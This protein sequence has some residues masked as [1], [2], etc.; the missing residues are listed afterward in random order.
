MAKWTILVLHALS[1]S[2]VAAAEPAVNDR[3]V[4]FEQFSRGGQLFQKHCAECH[5]AAAQGAPDWRTR[6]PDGRY[7]AP[8]LNGTGHAW[9][10]PPAALA[11]TIRDGTLAIGGSMPSWKD[12]LAE[13]DIQAIIGWLVS[14]W[15]AEAYEAWER[16]FG[17]TAGGRE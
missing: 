8:P 11:K 2:A 14:R 9:H 6:G 17:K 13:D 4:S 3:G 16:K 5:G 15:P 1:I 10:H 12:E 7:P